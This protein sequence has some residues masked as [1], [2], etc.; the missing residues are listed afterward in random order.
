MASKIVIRDGKQFVTINGV[1]HEVEAA[2]PVAPAATNVL[3]ETL[4][5]AAKTEGAKAQR[6]YDAEFNTALATSGIEGKAAEEFRA[7]FDGL[8]I[9]QIK[10][11]A[12]CAIAK[13]ATAV[14]EGTG[15]EQKK[16]KPGDDEA[17]I[18]ASEGKRFDEDRNL[19]RTWNLRNEDSTSAEYKGVRERFIA[20]CIRDHRE[21]IQ[22]KAKKAAMAGSAT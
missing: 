6:A 9:K 22:N 18:T 11:L 16:D 2:T 1:E 19:R 17:T 12:S 8:P 5:E 3:S 15:G 10:F 20:A 13:R 21:E 4:I 14:G 7:S